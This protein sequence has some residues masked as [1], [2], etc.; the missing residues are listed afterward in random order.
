VGEGAALGDPSAV[1]VGVTV[2]AAGAWVGAAVALTA[3]VGFSVGGAGGQT[4]MLGTM[5]DG[6]LETEGLGPYRFVD[7]IGAYGW[8]G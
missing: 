8:K 5:E 7:L 6:R 1:A 3:A 4:L 2:A